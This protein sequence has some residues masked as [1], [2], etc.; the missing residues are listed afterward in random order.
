[1]SAAPVPARPETY[2]VAAKWADWAIRGAVVALCTAAVAGAKWG[3]TMERNQ[4]DADQVQSST[5]IRVAK[6]EARDDSYQQLRTD[7]AVI[8]EQLDQQKAQNIRIEDLLSR[9]TR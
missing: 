5:G 1:M 8:K 2:T 9:L 7:I 3:I 4:H 6:L